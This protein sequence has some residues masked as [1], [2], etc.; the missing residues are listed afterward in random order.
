MCGAQLQTQPFK[1][2]NEIIVVSKDSGQ[3]LFKHMAQVLLAKS[4]EIDKSYPDFFAIQTTQTRVPD[5]LN[6]YAIF[7]HIINDTVYIQS[8]VY[9]TNTAILGD[10]KLDY[11][12]PYAKNKNFNRNAV[13]WGT[14]SDVANAI[15][16]NIFYAKIP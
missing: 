13:V 10:E 15:A 5:D 8:H 7:A 6:H 3:V 11:I 1:G 4:Y 16:G 2:C 12:C 9:L 14:L